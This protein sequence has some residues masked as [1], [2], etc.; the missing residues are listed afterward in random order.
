MNIHF[1]LIPITAFPSTIDCTTIERLLNNILIFLLS[2]VKAERAITQNG[3][4]T[5]RKW[6]LKIPIF[7]TE[8]FIQ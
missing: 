8:L 6:V 5:G 1:I 3:V 7:I 2:L 4:L